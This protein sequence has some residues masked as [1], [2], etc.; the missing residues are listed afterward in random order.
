MKRLKF[1]YNNTKREHEYQKGLVISAEKTFE[2]LCSEVDNPVETPPFDH[3]NQGPFLGL[4]YT[5]K[6]TQLRDFKSQ[7]EGTTRKLATATQPRSPRTF[8]SPT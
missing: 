3:D 8:I 7:A 2:K 6:G 1:T 5:N 4:Q